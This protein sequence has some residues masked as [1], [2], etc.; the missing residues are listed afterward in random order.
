MA[1]PLNLPETL[2]LDSGRALPCT[3]E[4]ASTLSTPISRLS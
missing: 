2:P 3:R 1:L 4:G